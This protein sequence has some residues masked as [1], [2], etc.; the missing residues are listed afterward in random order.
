MQPWPSG[1][2]GVERRDPRDAPAVLA[3]PRFAEDVYVVEPE[4]AV[5]REGSQLSFAEALT[6]GDVLTLIVAEDLPDLGEPE[7]TY[8][9]PGMQ[10]TTTTSLTI[11]EAA[12]LPTTPGILGWERQE[13]LGV[14]CGFFEELT[15]A[16]AVAVTPSA[17]AEPWAD[18]FV[19]EVYED[20][21]LV[22]T[23]FGQDSHTL[24]TDCGSG[25]DVEVFMR[26]TLPG[27]DVS[28]ETETVLLS[29]DLVENGYPAHFPNFGCS[30]GSDVPSGTLAPFA[31]VGLALLRRR[32][33]ER[34]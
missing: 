16:A 1:A 3:S 21:E 31:L 30:A 28:L 4:V 32:R 26:G 27:T 6:V 25:A 33:A 13:T 9:E 12:P 23:V 8:C 5:V 7:S 14:G 11:T 2:P 29:C 19:W 18:L 24:Q 17:E 20:G 34:A 15:G 10:L 22:D